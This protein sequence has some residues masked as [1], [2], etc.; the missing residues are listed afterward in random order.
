MIHCFGIEPKKKKNINI[1][2]RRK[3]K[4][5]PNLHFKFEN[6]FFLAI[7]VLATSPCLDTPQSVTKLSSTKTV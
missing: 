7:F 6:L 3:I 1:F 2:I 5:I 4:I